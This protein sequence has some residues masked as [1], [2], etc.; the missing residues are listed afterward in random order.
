MY[1]PVQTRRAYCRKTWCDSHRG[2]FVDSSS[3]LVPL[4]SLSIVRAN[5][6]TRNCR[7]RLRTRTHSPQNIGQV[8]EPAIAKIFTLATALA[9]QP[10]A[11]PIAKALA[12]VSLAVLGFAAF[13]E[14]LEAL[15]LAADPE[16]GDTSRTSVPPLCQELLP[17]AWPL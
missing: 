12:I 16:E 4:L 10:F 2:V 17:L 11:F 3:S 1:I 5:P 14:V 13:V 9:C 15:S 7:P 8:S 6:R